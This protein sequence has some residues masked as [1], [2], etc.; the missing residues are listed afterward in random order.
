MQIYWY[1]A[2]VDGPFPWKP[3][4]RIPAEHRNIVALA[5]AIDAAPYTGALFGTYGHDSWTTATSLIPVTRRMRFLIP[6]YPGVTS[7]R[8]LAQQALTFDDYSGGR[9]MFNLVNGTDTV[10]REYGV[11][12]GKDDRYAMSAEYWEAFKKLYAGEAVVHDGTHFQV[13]RNREIEGPTSLPVAPRQSPH[14]PLWGAGASPAGVKHA[15]QL[16]DTYLAFLN[17]PEHLHAQF[18]GARRAAAER[19]R[20]IRTGIAAWVIVRDTEEEAHAHLRWLLEETGPQW[21]RQQVDVDVKRTLGPDAS[22]AELRSDDPQM[23]RRIDALNAGRV[24]ELADLQIG[25][26]VFTG[27]TPPSALEVLGRGRGSY[28]VGNPRQVA[29]VLKDLQAEFGTEAFI[30]QAYPLKEEAER[31]AKLLLPLL[32]LDVPEPVA[33]AQE[34]AA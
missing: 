15:A 27:P 14:T 31:V 25:P 5:R 13:S 26:H 22:L 8:L 1:V 33:D 2:P 29:Q 30:L 11:K 32:D 24:P 6:I 16:V 7:P 10:L 20:H 28:I 21:L 4:G 18:D 23:Q 19:G 12:Q 34:V 9:L 17:K 3:E